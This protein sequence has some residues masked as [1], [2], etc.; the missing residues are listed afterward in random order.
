MAETV[1]LY[2]PARP[3]SLRVVSAIARTPQIIATS[4]PTRTNQSTVRQTSSNVDSNFKEIPDAEE[5]AVP[6]MF[7]SLGVFAVGISSIGC[8][9]SSSPSDGGTGGTGTG[10]TAT[11]G[12]GGAATGGAG[13][14]ATGGAGG[15]ATGG[16]G[17]L[18]AGGAGGLVLKTYSVI[19]NGA[20]EGPDAGTTATGAA[21]VTLN[22]ATGAVTVDGTFTGLTGNAT[23]AHIHGL[24]T[25]PATAPV[26]VPL[27]A[28]MATSG[29]LT[30]SGTLTSAQITGMIAGMTYLNIHT[31]LHPGGEIRGN[32]GP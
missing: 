14:A 29:T 17:G 10:G 30:G 31:A 20:M 22:T 1:R 19:L 11:G 18:A 27:T 24:A 7:L 21:T 25:P 23:A 4:F 16:A 28:T 26:I 32:I 3:T 15:A 12:A 6:L 13:G 9:S 8:S 2:I 5:V